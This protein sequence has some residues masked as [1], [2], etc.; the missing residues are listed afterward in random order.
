MIKNMLSLVLFLLTVSITFGAEVNRSWG[1]LAE[2]IRIGKKVVVTQM[3]LTRAEGKL[4]GVDSDSITVQVQKQSQRIRREDVFR[5][6][7]ADIRMRH[8][9]YGMAIGAAGGFALGAASVSGIDDSY[10]KAAIGT[11]IGLMGLGAGSAVGGALPIG[12]PLY[13]VEKPVKAAKS[14]SVRR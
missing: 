6:R 3:N 7:Y 5:V 9:L 2:S 10:N 8:T 12:P 11:I 4:L 13:E 14:S 1:T